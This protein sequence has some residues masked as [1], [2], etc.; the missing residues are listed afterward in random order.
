MS[1]SKEEVKTI[2]DKVVN[3]AKADGVE[4]AF[5]GGERSATRY[6]NS[7][8]TA[9]LV[10]HDQQVTITVYS[11]QKAASTSTHQ[12][13]DVSLRPAREQAQRRANRRPDTPELMPPVKPPQDS[14]AVE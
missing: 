7:T 12:F 11:G 10:E 2:T 9:N 4:V 5:A 14:L 6:A 1:Y 13:D 8:I 3:M